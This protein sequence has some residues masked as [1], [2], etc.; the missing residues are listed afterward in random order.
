MINLAIAESWQTYQGPDQIKLEI[1][2]FLIRP[3]RGGSGRTVNSEILKKLGIF[4]LRTGYRILIKLN[5]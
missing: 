4:N 5:I 2:A 3:S 1:V